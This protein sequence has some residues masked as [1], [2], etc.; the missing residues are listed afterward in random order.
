MIHT[1]PIP[2]FASKELACSCCG[3]IKLDAH[4]AASLAYL[5]SQWNGPLK[6]NSVCRCPAHN[7]RVG[8]HPNSLHLTENEKWKTTGTMAADIDWRGWLKSEKIRFARL[9]HS[10]GLR[11]GLHDGFCHVDLGRTLGLS[12]RPFVYGTWSNE[13][14]PDEVL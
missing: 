12:P 13:F 4:F 5:R 9:A 1:T 6:S 11:V 2:F 8:G 7:K 10:I 14:S 3:V